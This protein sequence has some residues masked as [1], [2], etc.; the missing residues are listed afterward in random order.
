MDM[1]ETYGTT[2]T[3]QYD[4]PRDLGSVEVTPGVAPDAVGTTAG[5]TSGTS[6]SAGTTD[7]AKDEARA[8]GEQAKEGARHVAEVGKDEAKNV[9][10]ETGQQAKELW[11]Q[12]RSQLLEQSAQQQTRVADGLR[13]LSEE[14]S[15]MARGSEQQG[16][17]SDLAH[18]ASQRMG[19][20][21]SWLDQRDPGSL[22]SEVKQFAR[23]R[24]GAFL[25]TAAVLGLVGG[26][27]SRG[28]V[29]EHQDQQDQQGAGTY[30]GLSGAGSG[31]TAPVPVDHSTSGYS[32]YGS[33]TGTVTPAAPHPVTD[34]VVEAGGITGVDG[35]VSGTSTEAG[36]Y[37]R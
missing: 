31:T 10:Q 29:A 36:E 4:T 25:A 33:P 34:P 5:G 16:V 15:G 35:P 11:Q 3:E 26:R 20:V 21:A 13:S 9:V 14:L 28:L 30:T 18:Q 24:P 1:S 23:Q 19:D 7:V 27:L 6:G 8:T 2:G 32:A 17:A 12:T 37:P 22:V